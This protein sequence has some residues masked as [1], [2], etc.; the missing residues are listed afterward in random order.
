MNPEINMAAPATAPTTPPIMAAGGPVL[1]LSPT[2]S[3]L[4]ISD[5]VTY[6]VGI[7]VVTS[8]TSPSAKVEVR[9]TG[10]LLEIVRNDVLKWVDI[11]AGA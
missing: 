3:M 6:T 4:A 2:D 11:V 5:G 7:T 10:I 8:I 9:V 1:L